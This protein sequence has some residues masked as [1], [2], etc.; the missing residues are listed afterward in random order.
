MASEAWSPDCSQT[1]GL[2]VRS[3]LRAPFWSARRRVTA[4]VTTRGSLNAGSTAAA[5]RPRPRV[6]GK[7]LFVGDEK[8][9]VRGVTYGPFGSDDS[10][11]EYRQDA[12]D[13]DFA[14][15]AEAGI[16]AIRVYTV[17]PRWLLDAAAR[18]GLWVMVGMPWEQHVTF[19]DD[20][21]RAAAIERTVRDAVR[22][23][24]RHPAVLA[25]AVGN[26]IPASIV[27]WHGRRR[28]ER[29]IERL[30]RAAKEEDP[31]GNV[32]Y[33]NFPS[34]EYLTLPFLDFHCFNVYLEDRERLEGYMARLQNIADERPLMMAEIGLDSRRN[35]EDVQ[36]EMLDWQIRSV[37]AAGAAGAFVFAWT[38][39]W[40]RGGFTIEDWDFGV[41]RRDRTAKP[42]LAAVTNAYGELP[43]KPDSRPRISVVVCSY[44]GA[45][46]IG[47]CLAAIKE[48]DYPE[49]E[50]IVVNDGS[51]D[52]T[53]DIAREHG[54]RVIETP[55][56]GLALARNTGLAAA[57]GEIVAYVDDDAAPDRD[58]LTYLADAFA[59]GEWAAVGGPN[60]PW[61]GAGDVPA[62]ISNAPGGPTHVLVSDREAEH[63]PGCNMAFRRSVLQELKGFDPQFHAAGDDV[64]ICWR[65]SEAGHRIGFHA[66]ASVW[67]HRR[68]SVGAYFRQQRG[69]GA[70]EALLERKWP[71]RYSAAGHVDWGGR[72]YGNGSAQHR[73]RWHWR[74]YYGSWGAAPFQSIYGPSRG[75]LEALPLM[76][77][78]YLAIAGLAA[79][80]LAGLVWA[81]LLLFLPLFAAA[82]VALLVDAALGA[83]RARFENAPRGLELARLRGL[84]A[85]LYLLQPL[86]R[87]AGRVGGR[88]TPWRRRAPARAFTTPRPASLELW[89]EAWHAPEERAA[90]LLAQLSEQG[91]VA[92]AGGDWDRWD[93]QVRGGSV[94]GARLRTATEEHGAGRQLVRVRWWPF[95]PRAGRLVAAIAV[96]LAVT[97]W[98][99]NAATAATGFGLVALVLVA[100]VAFECGVACGAVRCALLE[101]VRPQPALGS[102]TTVAKRER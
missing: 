21:R 1:F 22:A 66:G 38:D 70:A 61:P 30:Y 45:A 84:T 28:I 52:T 82:V 48:L 58:W 89:S 12:V 53:A 35:G 23:C 77:E 51:T 80:S 37:F 25:Y 60:V 2:F 101:P 34:T 42:A 94:G 67:H 98:A 73:G 75:L 29:F 4:P 44:N 93:L 36:A 83:R 62:A 9:L 81:P 32:T 6:G 56:Q 13:P 54:A 16:N 91:S 90:A 18:N 40:H 7:F 87:L 50:L 63:I 15:I 97:A 69:Y 41:T 74:I 5:E 39:E 31:D 72:L 65:L 19:L 102:L 17:P 85:V 46:T 71:E 92:R 79:L 43:L 95:I 96:A 26:E 78:W 59:T 100:R 99:S 55:N 88:L 33:V 3:N 86:A 24:G 49:Y 68:R 8:L 57:S 47:D 11:E 10:G 14:A 76:P 20:R 27:R 64:D